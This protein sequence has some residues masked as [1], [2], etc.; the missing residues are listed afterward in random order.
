EEY[1]LLKGLFLAGTKP[2]LKDLHLL[3]A[4]LPNTFM[5]KPRFEDRLRGESQRVLVP[6]LLLERAGF[7]APLVAILLDAL[8]GRQRSDDPLPAERLKGISLE[9]PFS[10][11]GR[12]FPVVRQLGAEEALWLLGCLLEPADL[13]SPAL[14]QELEDLAV[15]LLASPNHRERI[16]AAVLLGL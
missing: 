14:R 9:R 16:D 11:H 1:A 15:P 10:E 8:R 3:I 7:R 2:D 12:P 13:R 4:L 6:R 5:E